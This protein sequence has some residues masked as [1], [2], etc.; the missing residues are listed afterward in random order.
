MKNIEEYKN[1][2]A[3]QDW[4]G[5]FR[6]NDVPADNF[7]TRKELAVLGDYLE[8]DEVVFAMASGIMKQTE[9]S[10]FTDSNFNTWLIVLTSER[11]LCLDHAFISSSVDTQS[12]RFN[13]VQ[14]VSASQGYIFG[15]ISIDIGSRMIVVDNCN[16]SHVKLF[17][18]FA[19]DLIR[20]METIYKG[21][22]GSALSV[23]DEIQKL[24]DLH[25]K[26][27]LTDA[28]LSEAKAKLISKL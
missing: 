22:S 18:Q 5:I 28:E 15:K 6:L 13:Q 27:M 24:Y 2:T 12:I 19:N 3:R 21:T 26:G 4:L 10:N 23:T 17:A 7:G 25:T 20:Q 16:K 14:A 9:T 1:L 11:I 8:K